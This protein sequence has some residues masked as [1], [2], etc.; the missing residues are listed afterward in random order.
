M[1]KMMVLFLPRNKKSDQ[2]Q[3]KKKGNNKTKK[4]VICQVLYFSLMLYREQYVVVYY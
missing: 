2:N 1:I 4:G 3:R